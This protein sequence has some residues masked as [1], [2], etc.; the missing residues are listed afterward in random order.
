MT[1]FHQPDRHRY[2]VSLINFQKDMPNIPIDGIT[3][4]IRPRGEKL[5]RVMRLPEGQTIEHT[6]NDGIVTF[7]AGHLETL[8]MFAIETM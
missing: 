1:V 4:R 6:Q 8:A 5:H 2:L 7:P 3:V